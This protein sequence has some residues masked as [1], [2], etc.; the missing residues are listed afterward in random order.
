LNWPDAIGG[1]YCAQHRVTGM[2]DFYTLRCERT[3]CK[4]KNPSFAWSH[5]PRGR[6]CFEHQ[7]L[8]M[9]NKP[10]CS[11]ATSPALGARNKSD[12]AARATT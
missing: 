11:L 9:V 12:R 2:V 8:G 1:R 6:F 3:N 10:A 5:E 7:E 4:S